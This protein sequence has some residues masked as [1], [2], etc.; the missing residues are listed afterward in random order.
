MAIQG[1]PLFNQRVVKLVYSEFSVIPPKR[2][3]LLIQI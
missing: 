1:H 3:T 2:Y